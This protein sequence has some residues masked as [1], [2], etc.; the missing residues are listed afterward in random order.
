M[1]KR[2]NT[3]EF[4]AIVNRYLLDSVYDFEGS[5]TEKAQHIWA[6]FQSEY[7]YKNNRIRLP[8]LQDR[9]A[10]WLSGLALNI[11]FSY[12]D[13]RKRAESWHECKLTDSDAERIYH[14]WFPFLASKL[15]R[16]CEKNGCLVYA[17][18]ND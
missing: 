10:E 15:I 1:L 6:R 7:N 14:N 3:K 18:P 11:E 13:I 17:T 16:L 5:D 12:Y 2:T 4:T 8:N 9:V